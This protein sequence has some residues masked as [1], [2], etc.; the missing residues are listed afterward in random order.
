MYLYELNFMK[1]DRVAP[2]LADPSQRHFNTPS[3]KIA[4]M[5][6]KNSSAFRMSLGWMC[7]L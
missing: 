5:K 2:M 3:V 4:V 6:F 1:L 7:Y